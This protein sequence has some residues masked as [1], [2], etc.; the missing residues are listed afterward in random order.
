MAKNDDKKIAYH[1]RQECDYYYILN[2]MIQVPIQL[3]L[4]DTDLMS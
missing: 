2:T 3:P 1:L 4:V